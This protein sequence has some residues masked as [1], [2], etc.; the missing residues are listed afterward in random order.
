VAQAARQVLQRLDGSVP[1]YDLKT[2]DTQIG[3]THFLDR[4]LAWLSVAFGFLATLLASVGIYGITAFS[5]ARR[6][7]EIGIRMALG[8]A[9]G[10]VLRL[11]MREVLVLA[12]GGLIVGVPAALAFGKVIES[13][14]FEM[15]AGDPAVIAGA[16][17]AVLLVSAL[18]AYLPAR[19]A[20]GID[21]LQAL[22]WE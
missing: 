14:L 20:T 1:I 13:Q 4:I 2:L 15:K 7:Q 3:E 11:V 16:I 5:V 21:P 9:R 6:T 17:T 22:R 8:A 18:A 10:N 19:R 12:A